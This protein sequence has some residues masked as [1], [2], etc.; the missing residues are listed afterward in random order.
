MLIDG[1]EI[2]VDG[3]GR[4]KAEVPVRKGQRAVEIIAID[5]N[6]NKTVTRKDIGI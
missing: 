5:K 3:D 1:I 2:P 6:G 4:Y